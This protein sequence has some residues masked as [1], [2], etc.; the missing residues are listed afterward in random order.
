MTLENTA[1]QTYSFASASIGHTVRELVKLLESHGVDV[2]NR[3]QIKAGFERLFQIEYRNLPQ[4]GGQSV[5]IAPNH[6]S[7]FDA[8]IMGLTLENIMILSKNDWVQNDDLM[9]FLSPHY[10]LVGIDR[11]NMVSQ[12]RALVALTKHLVTPGEAHHALIFPQGTISD[13]NRNSLERVQSGVFAL[14]HKA[15]V[16]V[17]PVYI[18]QPKFNT[19][20]RIVFGQPMPIPG[21]KEDCRAAWLKAVLALQDSLNPPARPPVLTEKHQN[22]NK[23]GDAYF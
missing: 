2:N 10:S 22:N 11:N 16:P 18:E 20:T 8:L 1:A 12:A 21:R 15:G 19:P 5:I 4:P 17:L 13:V 9:Q 14:S 23:P 6:V 3:R 7:D